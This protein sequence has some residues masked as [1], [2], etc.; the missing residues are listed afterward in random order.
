MI[1]FRITWKWT[2]IRCPHSFLN[3]FLVYFDSCT[4]IL[5]NKPE[6]IRTRKSICVVMENEP[7]QIHTLE[8]INPLELFRYT[9]F[10]P[11]LV[12]K[13]RTA[14]ETE[15]NYLITKIRVLFL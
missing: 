8:A 4:W 1:P 13:L 5:G 12:T 2:K 7:R 10:V 3:V 15:P 14:S 11:L 9:L 6:I